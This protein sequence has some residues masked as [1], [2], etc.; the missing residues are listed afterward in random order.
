MLKILERNIT[1]Q[2]LVF[3]G[4][5]VIPLLLGG[6]E[7]YFFQYDALQQ[8]A[9]QA[10][11]GL[12]QA[13]AQNVETQVQGTVEEAMGLARNQAAIQFD[14]S[15]LISL[16]SVSQQ[17]HPEISEYVVCDP[18]GKIVLSYPSASKSRGQDFSTNAS[19]QSALNKNKSF[20]SVDHISQITS[21]AV[22]SVATRITNNQSRLVGVL[23]LNL[24]LTQLNARLIAVQQR[25]TT[26]GEVRIWIIDDNGMPVAN[27]VGVALP[28][29]VLQSIPALRDALRGKAGNLVVSDEQRDWLYSYVPVSNTS[30]TVAVGRPTDATFAVAISFQHSLIIA[31]IMLL[32]GASVFWF[33]MHGWVVA[34]LRRLAQ[35]AGKIKP[36]QVTKVT[37][38]K[39]LS[40]EKNRQDE[41][42]RLVNAFAA[43]EEEIFTLFRKSDEQSYTR[44]Q[45]LDAIMRSMDE[46]VLLEDPAGQVIYANRRF[47][48]FVG[49]SNQEVS[50]ASA[51]E[52][53]LTERLEAL[54]EAPEVYHEALCRAEAG[55][56]VQLI[57]FWMRGYYNQVG[58]LVPS[59][60]HIRMRLFQVHDMVGQIIGRG[61]IFNDVTQQSEAEQVKKNLLAIVSHELRTPLTAIKGYA[62]S[63]LETDIEL[64]AMT[65]RDF[66][67]RI[68]EE[69]DR[70]AELVTGLLEMSQ[71]EAGTLK[72]A[73]SYCR[74]DTL[75]E[76]AIAAAKSEGLHIHI[77]LP[78]EIPVLYI[79]R[80]R[81]EMVLRNIL[82]NA[83]RY[84]GDEAEVEII[85]RS[86]QEHEDDGIYVSIADNGAGLPGDLTERI[87]ERFYQVD[88]GR[89]RSGSG[90]GLGLAICRGFVE[91]HGGRIWAEN[92]TEN[93]SGAIFHIWLPPRLLHT[94]G[95]RSH[96]F[97]LG[98]AL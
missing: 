22:V 90:V 46:G 79:D 28:S 96:P 87:F 35:A 93:G 49:V 71:L 76:R 18:S 51:Q 81:M 45:T 70:M 15:Q 29:N 30:W 10:D 26:N 40:R 48:R 59:R 97:E 60:R 75:I 50:L 27:T 42:G 31:L 88:G 95:V 37:D 3:Y 34:P 2:L 41:I 58:Q 47:T 39:S 14:Q 8:S 78:K 64:D 11:L 32:A 12:A 38:S 36:D 52:T 16:F 7:L 83:Q 53:H 57:E 21:S 77:S 85:A 25:L 54:M 61:K 89:E 92:R 19:F 20:V 86:A 80:R 4:L 23:I 1:L 82:E 68:V 63:L 72:L 91:A 55:D 5:F 98:K 94:A 9:Q 13:I 6:A 73:P 17:T 56:G 62:T 43:M 84:A 33:A 24:S 65:Q 44:L 66:L 69:E 67:Q 74:L